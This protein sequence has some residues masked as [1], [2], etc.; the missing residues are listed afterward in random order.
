VLADLE[1]VATLHFPAVT[2]AV[3]RNRDLAT[4]FG[5]LGVDDQGKPCVYLNMDVR[6]R[7]WRKVLGLPRKTP[8]YWDNVRTVEVQELSAFLV[9]VRYRVTCGDGWYRDERGKRHYFGV[10]E[11]LEGMDLKR[12][13]TTVALRAA[14]VLA[15][16]GGIGLRQL[17]WLLAVLFGLDVS[18]SALDRWIEEAASHLPNAEAM[19]K[20]LVGQKPV[21]EAHFDEI[22]PR[23]KRKRKPVLV[24]RDEHGRILVTEEVEHRDEDEVVRFLEKLKGWGLSFRTFYIDHC[25]SYAAAIKRVF[26]EAQ[27]QYDY[28][29]ILQNVWR[30]VWRAF[31]RH[32]K[33]IKRRS[34]EVDTPWYAAKLEAL[35]KRLWENRGLIFKFNDLSEEDKAKLADL[36]AED[37]YLGTIRGFLGRVRGIFTDSKGELGARQRLGRLQAREEVKSAKPS[38]FAKAAKFLDDHFEHMVTFLRVPHVKRNSL[39]E[40]GMRTL[41]RLEQGHD[42]FRS[43]EGRDHYVRLFQ[44]I[45]YFRWDVQRPDGSLG[46]S[47][48]PSS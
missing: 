44:A 29:H 32:R 9:P 43:A 25:A 3:A 16:V 28:F 30:T 4:G 22:F 14:V 26:P 33:D 42:G 15:V 45:R 38:A 11:H 37:S 41:R 23:G 2:E 35:A 19:V 10:D 13:I 47:P 6:R 21:T 36:I 34:G 20:L 27:I 40:T 7:N 1:P 5:G 48:P 46:I 8:L 12:G 18:K 31:V 24:V 39:A 17:A